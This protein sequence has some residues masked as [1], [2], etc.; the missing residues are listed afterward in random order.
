APAPTSSSASPAPRGSTG[1]REWAT[2]TRGDAAVRPSGRLNEDERPHGTKEVAAKRTAVPRGISR[3]VSRGWLGREAW[4]GWEVDSGRRIMRTQLVRWAAERT[5]RE[6]RG[7]TGLGAREK[8]KRLSGGIGFGRETSGAPKSR[9]FGEEGGHHE[10]LPSSGDCP[11]R[12]RQSKPRD[13]D[14]GEQPEPHLNRGP[15]QEERQAGEEIPPTVRRWQAGARAHLPRLGVQ[16]HSEFP[17]S[18]G[19]LIKVLAEIPREPTLEPS[20]FSGAEWADGTATGAR[21]AQGRARR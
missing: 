15:D 6:S 8:R 16:R 20:L 5:R 7:G 10:E 17:G 2:R 3:S 13:P 14:A 1:T 21:V 18:G 4:V 19:T 12:P 11:A 9:G